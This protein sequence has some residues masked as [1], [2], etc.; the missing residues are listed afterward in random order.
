MSVG[1]ALLLAF[2]IGIVAGL[3]SVTAPAVTAWAAYLG[4]INLSGSPLAFMGTV[5]AAV[6]FA[7]GAL[8]EF[9]TDQLPTTPARTTTGPLLARIVMGALSGA[10]LTIAAGAS[11]AL[12]ALIGAIGGIAGAFAGYQARVGLVR[13]LNVKDVMVAVPEDLVAIGVGLLLVSRFS[14]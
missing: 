10:C 8:A 13:K 1:L 9:V 14:S 2:G 12:G 7:L 4:W 5:W 3:R 6:I 11:L